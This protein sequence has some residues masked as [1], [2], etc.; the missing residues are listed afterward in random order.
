MT[1]SK[2]ALVFGLAT[3]AIWSTVASAFKLSLRVLDP[4][5]L[6]LLACA[7]SVAAL[8]GVLL[9]QKKFSLVGKISRNELLRCG[10]LGALNPFLYYVILFKAYDLLPAQEAQPINY[11]WAITLTLLSIPLLKQRL[12]PKDFLAILISYFGVVVI[13]AHGD[14]LAL[15]FSNPGGVGLA[16]GSTVIWALYWIFNTKSSVDPTVGLF[17][18]FL[19]GLPLILAATLLFSELPDLTAQGVAGAAYVGFF[20]MG[21]TFALW[22]T[23]MKYA[24]LPDGGGTARVANLIFLSPFLSLVFI[25]LLT[26]ERILPATVA[27]LGFIVAGNVLMQYKPRKNR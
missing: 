17:L 21:I 18:N 8:A 5:Q 14:L 2:K 24:A 1:N 11:T 15:Q 16:L 4:L 7:A 23:A 12:R 25:Q 22:L 26:G 19:F 9:F 27:G 20:E 6:L 10:L 13:S 3:V